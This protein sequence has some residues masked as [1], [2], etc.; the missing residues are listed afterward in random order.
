M[1]N[2]AFQKQNAVEYAERSHK[3]LRLI[4]GKELTRIIVKHGI[5]VR[6][7]RTWKLQKLDVDFFDGLTE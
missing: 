7:H 4:D 3:R 6:D 2:G 5:G 1:P